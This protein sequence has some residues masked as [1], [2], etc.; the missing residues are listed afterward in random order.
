[1]ID[2]NYVKRLRTESKRAIKRFTAGEEGCGCQRRDARR[3]Q[4]RVQWGHVP[5]LVRAYDGDTG[6]RPIGAGTVFW[7]SPDIGLFDSAGVRV[8]TTEIAT[9]KPYTIEVTATNAGDIACHSCQVELF[10]DDSSIGFSVAASQLLGCQMVEVPREGTA[11]ARF[12]FTAK[13]EMAGHRCL[14]AR[15]CSI[16]TNDPADWTYFD[17]NA[18]HHI[19]QQNLDI[20]QQASALDFKVHLDPQLEASASIEPSRRECRSNSEQCA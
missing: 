11:T 10:L 14:F 7:L 16:L 4:T 6:N 8:A 1:M 19:G 20:V 12:P 9:G 2:L 17:T 18:D 13:A 3:P 15:I 5:S